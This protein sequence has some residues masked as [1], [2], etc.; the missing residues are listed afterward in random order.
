M[1]KPLAEL[2]DDLAAG[3]T[4]SQELT[5]AAL[6]RIDDPAGEGARAFFK[7]Y[8][9]AA[10]ASAKASDQA[11]QHGVVPSLLAGIPVSIK[12]LCDVAGEVTHAGSIVRQDAPPAREDAPTVARLRAAGAVIMGR[13]NM[14]EFAMGGLGTNDHYGTPKNPWDR[15]TGRVPGGSTSGGA[16]SVSDG[17]AAAALGTDTAGSV[18]I[19]AALC[20]MAGFKPTA[21]RV[22][23][24]GI[25]P[26]SRTLDSVGPLAPTIQCCA[27][28]D[29]IFAGEAPREIIPQPLQG[30]LQ[31]LRFAVPKHLVLDDLDPDV[32]GGFERSLSKLSAAGVQISHIDFPELARIPVINRIGGFSTAEAYALHR[33]VL[34]RAGNQYDRNV[35]ARIRLGETWTAADYLDLID[36]RAE[37]IATAHQRSSPFDAIVM[38]TTPIVACPIDE[39]ADG[40]VW[41]DRNRQ[42]LRN[43]IVSNFLD[44]CSLTVPCHDPGAAPVG[45]ML[46]GEAMADHRLLQ[47]GAAVEACIRPSPE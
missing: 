23:T 20:G 15:K 44:R 5:E 18:R 31:G 4:T 29:A 21:R 46:M 36:I 34:D 28:V 41:V 37:M 19:P 17:M 39:V 6:A 22:P 45:F 3:R 14:V 42:Y 12:D 27:L 38:P 47:I 1:M 30:L 9:E 35:A 8:H 26:L 7:V 33:D 10:I 32:S 40:D 43:T 24:A 13:T 25:F 11:R 2:A 16:V